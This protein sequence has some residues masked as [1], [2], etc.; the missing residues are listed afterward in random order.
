MSPIDNEDFLG[1][2]PDTPLTGFL[3]DMSRR[4]SQDI[5][6]LT[7]QR[8]QLLEREQ[9]ILDTESDAKGELG[10]M[11]L[12]FLAGLALG[13]GGGSGVAMGMIGAGNASKSY[14]NNLQADEKQR[15]AIL[16]R[17]VDATDRKMSNLINF[18]QSLGTAGLNAA[19]TYLQGGYPGTKPFSD[20]IG[21]QL[22]LYK[23]QQDYSNLLG[24]RKEYLSG[25]LY[26]W[27]SNLGPAPDL[28]AGAPNLST[29]PDV[30]APYYLAAPGAQP[31]ISPTPPPINP[32]WA[33]KHAG[34]MDLPGPI[35]DMTKAVAAAEGFEF[36]EGSP[37]LTKDQS[38]VVNASARNLQMKGMEQRRVI[39]ANLRRQGLIPKELPTKISEPIS[40]AIAM[41]QSLQ[42]LLAA[43]K[44]AQADPS[45]PR[46]ENGYARLT[47]AWIKKQIPLD[48]QRNVA[49]WLEFSGLTTALAIN[50]KQLS[51]REGAVFKNF[52]SGAE[53]LSAGWL[54]ERYGYIAEMANNKAVGAAISGLS[55]GQYAG[56]TKTLID[57]W[58]GLLPPTERARITELLKDS[59][60][61][62]DEMLGAKAG[63][64][65][66]P[67]PT[68]TPTPVNPLIE[69]L[70]REREALVAELAKGGTQ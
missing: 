62:A 30:Q 42:P 25:N 33:A 31:E 22:G 19:N 39:D 36:E 15:L 46:D 66:A 68:A 2:L 13:G 47:A 21:A 18:N 51:D 32:A 67:T 41:Q 11:A 27:P 14:Y 5:D 70:R 37:P 35:S 40:G 69:A 64:M 20:K 50:G 57:N 54:E 34:S 43:I 29:P 10:A 55:Q 53:P 49:Q 45:L 1:G 61:R 24:M 38:T 16:N 7:G 65:G 9:G 28:S 3:L 52:L 56:Y 63:I 44:K 48:Q 6:G 17:E 8:R 59:T 58:L 12:P 60:A 26:A 4:T 23:Q